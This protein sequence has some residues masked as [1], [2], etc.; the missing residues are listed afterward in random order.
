MLSQSRYPTCPGDPLSPPPECWDYRQLP[1][2]PR[3]YVDLGD[4]NSTPHTCLASSLPAGLSPHPGEMPSYFFISK[5]QNFHGFFFS[6]DEPTHIQKKHYCRSL[7]RALSLNLYRAGLSRR[8]AQL[9]PCLSKPSLGPPPTSGDSV[10]KAGLTDL[11][12]YHRDVVP[13]QGLPVEE[14]RCENGTISR[15][16]VEYPVHICVSIHR[17]PENREDLIFPFS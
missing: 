16:N 3:L 12:C 15:I 11:C 5:S 4:P 17:I 13:Q 7:P 14:F 1:Y 2:P 8:G 10:A 6:Q 9:W